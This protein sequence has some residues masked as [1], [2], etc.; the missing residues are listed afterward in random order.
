MARETKWTPEQ[1]EAITEDNCNLLV[2]AAAGAG[3]TAVLVERIIRKI[4]DPEN[5]IDIDKLLIVTFT[6]AAAAE[7]RERIA[8]AISSVLE[9]NP[10]S[11]R[12][13]RQL[14]LLNKASITTLHSFF[15]EVIRN[16]FHLTDIDPGFRIADET[17]ALLMQIEVINELFEERYEQED[18]DFFNLL[19]CYGGNRDD[20]VLQDMVLNLYSFI[21]SIPWPDQ[22]LDKMTEMFNVNPGVD[23]SETPWGEVILKSVNVEL[24]GLRGML[25]LAAEALDNEPGLKGYRDVFLEDKANVEALIKV[26]TGTGGA[27]WDRVYSAVRELTFSR[28]PRAGKEADRSKQ[29]NVKKIRDDVK[30][31]IKRLKER[32]FAAESAE[33]IEDLQAMYPVMKSLAGLTREFG[34]RY[35]TKKRKKSVVDFNDLEHFCLE[36]LSEQDENGSIKPSQTAL[37]YRE[38]YEEI[39][40]DEYQDSNLVQEMMLKLISRED[41]GNPN[42]FMVGDVKQSIYRFR[43]AKPE[44]FLEKYRSYSPEKGSL[45][46]KILLFKNFRSR[47]EILDGVNF[48][49]KQIMSTYIGELDYTDVEALNPGAGYP[50]YD[51]KSINAGGE[52]ELHLIQTGDNRD[53]LFFR[54]EPEGEQDVSGEPVEMEEIPDTVQC[55]ARLAARRI[56]ELMQP[57]QDGRRFCIFD[58]NLKEYREL[59]YRDIVILLRTTKN[60]SEVFMEELREMG[61]PAFADTGTGFFKTSEVQVVLSLLQVI[62]NPLQDIPLL[63]VLRSPIV[64]FTT[65]ELAELRLADR[66]ADIYHAL[67]KL[68]QGA[69]NESESLACERA[70]PDVPDS[71]GK[72]AGSRAPEKAAAFLSKLEKWRDMALYMSTDQLLYQ[73]YNETGYYAMVGAMPAGDQRQ[74]NLRILFERARQFEETSYKGLFNFIYFIDKLKSSQGDMGSAKILGENDNVVRIM[75]IHKS[76]GLEFPVVFLCGC[77]KKFNMQDTNKS[78]LFHQELG[79]GPDVVHPRR[80]LRYPSLPKQAIREKVWTESLSEEMRILYVAMTRAREKLIITGA[81]SDIAKEMGKWAACASAQGEKLPVYDIHKG[82]RFLDW[83]CPALLRHKDSCD[84]RQW[85]GVELPKEALVEDLSVWNIR[86]WDKEQVLGTRGAE[87]SAVSEDLSWAEDYDKEDEDNLFYPEVARR[88]GWEYRFI[89]AT[90]VPAMI[91]VSELKRRFEAQMRDDTVEPVGTGITHS[92]GKGPLPRTLPALIKKPLFLQERKG[93]SG[94]EAGTAMHFVMQHLDFDR[95]EYA[96]QIAEMVDRDL[97][98]QQQAE[99]VD[100]GKIEEFLASPLGQRL[101]AAEKVHREVPFQMELPCHELYENMQGEEYRDETILLQGIIDCFFEEEEGIVLLDYKTDYVPQGG[102]EVIR[103]RYKTQITYYARA[104]EHLTG[105]KVIGKYIYLFSTGEI[106]EYS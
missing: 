37:N 45:F 23:L 58:K 47:K 29:E 68:A 61:I 8:L 57:D 15:L 98:T 74:A 20:Q 105:K 87:D 70:D 55:E 53:A 64:G 3:K 2:A 84:L 88:L 10:Y 34:A 59:Q 85:G 106:L 46:R 5:P 72:G 44:L 38:R 76:K 1:L 97:L 36:L 21:Q 19:E 11:R 33:I 94:A 77:G 7:M 73:L 93:L 35:A 102:V 43:Q 89:N 66:K 32:I 79:F 54:D 50:E 71:G 41:A 26:T 60:W 49:F 69:G 39:L 78:I 83:I 30:A 16:N 51:C 62:D 99:C 103:N 27:R 6:N 86:L 100:V 104:L 42:V 12:L 65:G 52:T 75:S 81:V 101:M 96:E 67:C 24:K 80:R 95:G 17:E 9:E 92:G 14:T 18:Q 28:L 40:V 4:T 48:I 56:H 25:R 82:R 63:A 13:Q 91:S 22:W 90:R 31:G